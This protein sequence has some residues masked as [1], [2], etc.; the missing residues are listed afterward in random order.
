M[1]WRHPKP[2][3]VPNKAYSSMSIQS[4]IALQ[5]VM[6]MHRCGY[7]RDLIPSPTSAERRRESARH[8]VGAAMRAR[9]LSHAAN[10]WRRVSQ[11]VSLSKSHNRYVYGDGGMEGMAKT[12]CASAADGKWVQVT[13]REEGT[14]MLSVRSLC[15]PPSNRTT[16]WRRRSI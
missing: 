14:H 11:R 3:S 15:Q 2:A 13:Q 12:E 5:G 7:Q 16:E 10:W 9:G 8:T 1:H 4:H 6:R